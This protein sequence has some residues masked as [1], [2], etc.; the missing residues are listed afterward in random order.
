MRGFGT[1]SPHPERLRASGASRASRNDEL[2]D[3][4][5]NIFYFEEK[6]EGT[7]R[8]RKVLEKSKGKE[9]GWRASEG[10]GE[11]ERPVRRETNSIKDSEK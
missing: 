5:K 8:N 11:G 9:G 3:K 10:K 2:T 4:S 7:A 6:G 1:T